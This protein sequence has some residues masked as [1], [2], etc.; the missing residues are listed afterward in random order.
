MSDSHDE[1]LLKRPVVNTSG[2]HRRRI[3]SWPVALEWLSTY[4]LRRPMPCTAAATASASGSISLSAR[5]ATVIRMPGDVRIRNRVP[6]SQ[7]GSPVCADITLPQRGAQPDAIVRI[8][9]LGRDDLTLYLVVRPQPDRQTL[10]QMA[11]PARPEPQP[12]VH[13]L[14]GAL[15]SSEDRKTQVGPVRLRR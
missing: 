8:S 15:I 11:D 1:R 14:N 6:D 12:P 4:M 2:H 9:V 5:S 13:P 7:P 10:Q 3:T